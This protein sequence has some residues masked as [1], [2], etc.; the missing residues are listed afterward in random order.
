[1]TF[2]LA[3]IIQDTLS[4][5]ISVFQSVLTFFH[6]SL[7]LSWGWSIIALT[8]T[9]RT[10]LIPLTYKQLKSTQSLQEHAPELKKLQER[11]KDDP[12][13]R[14]QEMM[15]FYKENKVNPFG[16]CLP[17]L[18]QMPVFIS[19]FYMLRT[20]LKEEICPGIKGYA[21]THGH[22]LST[23][24][25]TQFGNTKP[26]PA[27]APFDDGFFFIPD[28]TAKATGAVLVALIV[29]YIGSQLASSM[30][31]SVTADRNQRMLMMGLPFVFTIFIINFPAGLL[32]YWITTNMWTVG[33]ATIV[34]RMRLRTI[35]E[36]KAKEDAA[37]EEAGSIGIRPSEREPEPEVKKS[38][39]ESFGLDK[40]SITKAATDKQAS[41]ATK[42]KPKGASATTNGLPAA[43]PPR[44]PRQKKKRSGRRK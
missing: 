10:I 16:S 33:Q 1:M 6:D 37:W 28:I 24:S 5:L 35:A 12:E 32:L 3:N 25:C 44:P 38:F 29:L 19:L 26:T 31:M 40:G 18:F 42:P 17:L 13:K 9:V 2:P 21:S 23:Y 14:N 20:D 36:Q 41:K 11:Y 4:P 15:K 30:I 34:R 39:L 43:P 27:G 22:D 8:V 7:G